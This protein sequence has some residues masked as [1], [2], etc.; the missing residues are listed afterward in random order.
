ME[1]IEQDIDEIRKQRIHFQ[2]LHALSPDMWPPPQTAFGVK[3]YMQ[4]ALK[5]NAWLFLGIAVV[6]ASVMIIWLIGLG[7][8]PAQAISESLISAEHQ[9]TASSI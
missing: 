7:Q 4:L 6:I 9:I 8:E 3:K 2:E 5:G 1:C